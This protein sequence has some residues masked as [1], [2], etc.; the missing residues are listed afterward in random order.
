MT[1]VA[2]IGCGRIAQNAHLPALSEMPDVRIKYGCDIIIEKAIEKQKQR[3]SVDLVNILG[4]LF[5]KC[6]ENLICNF[7]GSN[8][9]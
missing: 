4:M 6:F 8:V 1:T 9:S 3:I 5:L 7:I 2:I